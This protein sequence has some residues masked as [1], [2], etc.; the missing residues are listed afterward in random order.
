MQGILFTILKFVFGS[1]LASSKKFRTAVIG[2]LT[3]LLTPILSGQLGMDPLLV[4]QVTTW[5][6]TIVVSLLAGQGMADWG[7]AVKPAD[8]LPL[9][10]PPALPD[11]VPTDEVK[12]V[13]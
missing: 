4:E 11:G 9:P 12:L 2:V 10:P 1:D 6:G 5:I 7:K 3:T 13:P 8:E